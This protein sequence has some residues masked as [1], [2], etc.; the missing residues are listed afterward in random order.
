MN[1]QQKQSKKK[2]TETNGKNK[3]KEIGNMGSSQLFRLLVEYLENEDNAKRD[4]DAN[5]ALM[6][7]SSD[8]EAIARG[9][10]DFEISETTVEIDN[11][12]Q[13]M[14]QLRDFSSENGLKEILMCYGDDKE[15]GCWMY[16]T[17]KFKSFSDVSKSKKPITNKFTSPTSQKKKDDYVENYEETS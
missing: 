9:Y 11:K 10:D 14:S 17:T 5:F 13:I 1:I 8:P 6:D 12:N 4:Q 3:E 2:K 15:S 7:K 16:P